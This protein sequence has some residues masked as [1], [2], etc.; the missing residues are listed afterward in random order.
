MTIQSYLLDLDANGNPLQGTGGASVSISGSGF[1]G[2][3]VG[4]SSLPGLI[5]NS[6]TTTPISLTTSGSAVIV[7]PTSGSALRIAKLVFTTPIAATVV[8]Q[9]GNTA[10][11]GSMPYPAGG[12]IVYDADLWPFKLTTNQPFIINISSGSLF[13]W[14][15]WWQE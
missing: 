8:L 2:G 15:T 3:S 11:S 9:N 5:S 4:V 1:T 7:A 6:L 13:G 10:I 12:G 14:T